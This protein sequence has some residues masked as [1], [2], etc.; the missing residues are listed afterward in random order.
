MLAASV[1]TDPPT[2]CDVRQVL[3][4]L[5]YFFECCVANNVVLMCLLCLASGIVIDCL[6]MRA[7]FVRPLLFLQRFKQRRQ[8]GGQGRGS[9]IVTSN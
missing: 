9:R 2:L 6:A 5:R 1:R 4:E 3:A 7:P 8:Y